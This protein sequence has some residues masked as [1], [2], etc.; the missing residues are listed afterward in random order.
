MYRNLF[1]CSQGH[2]ASWIEVSKPVAIKISS[3]KNENF[4]LCKCS[5]LMKVFQQNKLKFESVLS[6]ENT[7]HQEL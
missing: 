5:F 7:I 3:K 2:T 6:T 4:P 1:R